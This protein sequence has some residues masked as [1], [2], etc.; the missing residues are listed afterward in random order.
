M[1]PTTDFRHA[2]DDEHFYVPD[3]IPPMPEPPPDLMPPDPGKKPRTRSARSSEP[4]IYG[5]EEPAPI[6]LP[7][8]WN[9]DELAAAHFP[10]V[11]WIIPG[12]LPCGLAILA[13]KSKIGKS[14]MSLCIALSIAHGKKALGYYAL[15]TPGEVL[16]LALED[17]DEFMQER[18]TELEDRLPQ[19]LK[20]A[21]SWERGAEGVRHVEYYLDQHP[22]TRVVLIDVW[23]KFRP[24]NHGKGRV[25]AYV[26]AYES[27]TPLQRIAAERK[28]AIIVVMHAAKAPPL[29]GEW[30]DAILGTVGNIGAADT[31]IG[32]LK[33]QGAYVM[34]AKGR[35]FRDEV[36]VVID[37]DNRSGWQVIGDADE[38]LMSDQRHQIIAALSD[39]QDRT[40][41]YLYDHCN[42]TDA[43][44]KA[45][46]R[47]TLS[48]MAEDGQVIAMKG[49][50]YLKR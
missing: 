3:E 8:I 10:K 21:F 29:S 40:L 33:H 18:L 19:N 35:R 30:E 39:T 42:A 15:D 31:I 45:T 4:P 28:I 48:R 44:A 7:K 14:W 24:A 12:L 16:Y 26:E 41:S 27:L 49:G 17:Y 46:L 34:R 6:M 5:E 13:G 50:R 37:R 43:P 38:V 32:L 47:K 1:M 2:D 36:N 25:D 9:A 20:L 11:P 22:N 23:Q